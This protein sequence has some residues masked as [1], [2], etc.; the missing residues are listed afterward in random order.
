[1]SNAFT[2]KPDLSKWTKRQRM[3]HQQSK[4]MRELTERPDSRR[5]QQLATIL[6]SKK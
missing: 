3:N 2:A 6:E 5:R 1:M 4:V